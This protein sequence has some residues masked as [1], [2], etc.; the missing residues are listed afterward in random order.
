M[1]TNQKQFLYRL[2]FVASVLVV[3]GLG[4]GYKI[5][6]IQFLEGEKFRNLAKEKAIQNFIISPKRG[7]IYS[8]DGS[9]LASS[10][11]NYDIYFDAVT[12]SRKNFNKY[13]NPLSISLSEKF[14]KSIE[15]YKN[16]LNNS[17]KINKRYH[18]I[19]RNISINV[20]NDIKK[21]PLFKLGGVKGGLIIEKNY[22]GNI[23]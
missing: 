16:S 8:D 1:L 10:T 11:S 9:L 5:F 4:I 17:K 12:V 23:L 6:N 14:N 7:N 13:I 18:L 19:A 22:L 15:H 3:L 20:L 2:Y 21:M